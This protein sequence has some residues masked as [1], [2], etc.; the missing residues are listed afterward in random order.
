MTEIYRIS[1]GCWFG[2]V[3]RAW[4]VLVRVECSCGYRTR[5]YLTLDG[6]ANALILHQTQAGT[7]VA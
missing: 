6:A 7:R 4:L 3:H 5:P 2:G 1:P